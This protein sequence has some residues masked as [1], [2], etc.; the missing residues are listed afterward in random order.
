MLQIFYPG[1]AQHR[2]ALV[3]ALVGVESFQYQRGAA[4]KLEI[5]VEL[6]K[7]T[8][9]YQ[10]LK[11]IET[12]IRSKLRVVLGLDAKIS[13]VSPNTIQRFEG[14]AKRIRDLRNKEGV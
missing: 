7:A 2:P 8:D 13:L 9:D 3:A 5:R 14:K 4:D 10:E 1:P 6:L 12:A 11:N